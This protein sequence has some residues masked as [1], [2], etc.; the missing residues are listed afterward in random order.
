ML[1]YQLVSFIEANIGL[2]KSQ[3]LPGQ[4]FLISDINIAAS[5]FSEWK[6]TTS[7]NSFLKH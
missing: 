1:K 4:K 5:L 7:R 2:L 6:L 3:L